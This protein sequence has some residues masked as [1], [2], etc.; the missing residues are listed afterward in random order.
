MGFELELRR[1]VVGERR[2]RRWIGGKRVLGG[3]MLVLVL[4]LPLPALVL[5]VEWR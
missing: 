3:L 5:L 4:V 1:L 2:G